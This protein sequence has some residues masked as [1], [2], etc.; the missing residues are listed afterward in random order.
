MTINVNVK[1][2][3]QAGLEGEP[4]GPRL[5]GVFRIFAKW[6]AAMVSRKWVA[7][8]GIEVFSGPFQ[9]MRFLERS[10]E[11]CHL[12]KLIGC[13]EQPLHADLM[14]LL[15]SKY[16]F[17]LNIGSAE[18]YYAV[19]LARVAPETTVVA[20]DINPKALVACRELA[21][22]NGCDNLNYHEEFTP[23]DF[24]TYAASRVLVICDIEGA[25]ESLLNP[26]HATSLSGMDIVVESHECFVP[27]IT[28]LLQQRFAPT[29]TVSTIEDNGSR[30]LKDMPGWYTKL[31]HLDQLIGTWEW[32]AGPTPWLVMKAKR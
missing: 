28:E 14:A 7:Q 11:G 26:Q 13:Y 9:G 17:I 3:A 23:G 16:D 29:H 20:C 5:N 4:T 15:G 31:P 8:Q 27:G 30:Q 25:E 21:Q 22:L 12:P 10:A 6:K 2:L 1:K 19:G 32:R 18:G 24:E